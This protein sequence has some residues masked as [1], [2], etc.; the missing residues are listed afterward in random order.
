MIKFCKQ[1]GK[2]FNASNG[3]VRLCPTCKEINVKNCAQRNR[4]VGQIRRTK[5]NLRA[6]SIYGSD[7]DKLKAFKIGKETI[8]DT[9][10]RILL[11]WEDKQ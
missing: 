3:Y 6:T 2:E 4:E 8:A 1:C 9:L 7:T 11:D 10:H 5:L